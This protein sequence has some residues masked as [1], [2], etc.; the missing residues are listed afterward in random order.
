MLVTVRKARMKGPRCPC[1]KEGVRPRTQ[2]QRTQWNQSERM[3]PLFRRAYYSLTRNMISGDMERTINAAVRIPNATPETMIAAMPF[4]NPDDPDTFAV[5][6]RFA[7]KLE[8]AYA[9]VIA[10]SARTEA[11]RRGWTKQLNLSEIV[12]KAPK[13]KTVPSI[14]VN[15]SS[16]EFIRTRSLRLARELSAQTREVVTDILSEAFEEAVHPAAI[17]TRIKASVGLTRHMQKMV[18]R[19]VAAMHAGGFKQAAIDKER[20]KYSDQLRTRRAKT[21]ARTETLDAQT[22]GLKETWAKA[23]QE[24]LMP[25][26][27][28]KVWDSVM[29][30]R[31]S[32]VCLEL[33]GQEVGIDEQ[34]Y[35]DIVGPLDRPPAHPNCRSTMRLKFPKE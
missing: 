4:F 15:P 20:E 31:V 35:S 30:E 21:I 25:P 8:A 19:R 16:L 3:E 26:G 10:L 11:K 2:E 7:E 12:Q 1:H 27:A 32:D 33:D 23:K 18:K 24:G 13:P 5:W 9:E 29:D 6:N 22:V 17:V 34:F 28:K 14:P